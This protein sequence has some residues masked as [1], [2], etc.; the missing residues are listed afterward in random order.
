MGICCPDIPTLIPTGLLLIGGIIHHG[1]R[2][3]VTMI[4]GSG[5]PGRTM[6]ATVPGIVIVHTTTIPGTMIHTGLTGMVIIQL[7]Q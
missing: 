2:T 5:I 1:G 7:F 4:H 3:G 6:A